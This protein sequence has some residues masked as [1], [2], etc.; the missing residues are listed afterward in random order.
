MRVLVT[1][2]T[3]QLGAAVVDAFRVSHEVVALARADLD[4]ADR[5][6]VRDRV[7]ALRPD[8][9]VN[10]AAYNDVDRAERD[11]RPALEVNALAVLGLAQAA[12]VAG[13]ALVH[14]GTDFVF[15]GATDRPYIESD[16]P[17]PQSHYGCTKLLGELFAAGARRGYVLRVESIFG[18]PTAGL[19]AREG[20]LGGLVRKMRAGDEV[21]VFVDRVVTPSYAPD[22]AAAVVAILERNVEP[23]L[24]HCVNPGPA[25]WETVAREAASMLGLDARLKPVTVDSVPL[26][27][28]RPRYCALDPGKLAGAGV[29]IRPWR[30]AVRAWLARDTPG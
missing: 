27:A 14:F 3:G 13:A 10:C 28:R 1:G 4:I 6:A 29:V 18:G 12:D 30:E 5:A 7:R 19:S 23:G 2:A 17:R 8:A 11:C 22:V 21:P 16:D 24:Y 26:L 25:T 15:D 20:T 9:I